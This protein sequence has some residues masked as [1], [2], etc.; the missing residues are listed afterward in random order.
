MYSVLVV[1]L[2]DDVRYNHI[3]AVRILYIYIYVCMYVYIMLQITVYTN[4]WTKQHYVQDVSRMSSN[5][6][7]NIKD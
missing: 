4:I 5:N 7:Y 6:A 1:T 2:V 3:L